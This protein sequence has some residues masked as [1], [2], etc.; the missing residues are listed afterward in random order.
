[1]SVAGQFVG[2]GIQVYVP[3]MELSGNLQISYSRNV[4]SLKAKLNGY[5]KQVTST[6]LRGNYLRFAPAENARLGRDLRWAENTPRPVG[7]DNGIA[8]VTASFETQRYT[9]A[10]VLD[11][12]TIDV[13]NW[14]VQKRTTAAL[15]QVV[16][17]NRTNQVCAKITTAGNYPASQV[18]TATALNS[19]GFLQGG[20]PADPRILTT[21]QEAKAIIQ[22]GTFSR[23]SDGEL[24]VLMNPNTARR[25]SRTREL[26]EYLSNQVNSIGNITG[27]AREYNGGYLLPPFL[28]DTQ[29]IVEDTMLTTQNVNAGGTEAEVGSFAFPDNV[30]IV[31]ARS[32]DLDASEGEAGQ[33]FS[34]FTQF[35]YGKEDMVVDSMTDAWNKQQY[36]GIVDRFGVEITSPLTAV[37]VTNLFN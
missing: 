10:R 18:R 24:G 31:F 20:T 17:A 8:W 14:D 23:F 4:N 16:M 28:Y 11:M 9:D 2:N 15:A 6:G 21:I 12:T 29:V 33:D 32:G 34:A 5:T 27:K 13:A 25:L 7:R 3:L 37:L 26:R 22:T 30:M 1:M 19:S 36:F 35:V